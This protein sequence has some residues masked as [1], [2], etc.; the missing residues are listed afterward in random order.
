M[1]SFHLAFLL[2]HPTFNKALGTA[3]IA[4]TFTA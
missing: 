1:L 4:V 2:I 3:E